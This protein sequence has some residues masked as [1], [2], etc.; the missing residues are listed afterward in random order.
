MAIFKNAE[1]RSQ[2]FTEEEQQQL[3]SVLPGFRGLDERAYKGVDA[4]KNS[5]IFTAVMM[6]SSDVASL[7]LE[8]MK[9]N[10]KD[11]S[12]SFLPLMNIKP[13]QYYTGYQ[14]KFILMANA[15]LNGQSFAEIVR[16]GNDKPIAIYHLPNS[17]VGY[18]QSAAPDFNLVY[19]YTE[20]NGTE[21]KIQAADVIHLKFFSLDG[22]EGKSP[23]ISL[24][25]DLSTQKNSK[26]FLSNFFRNGTQSGGML[27]VKGSKLSKE[28]REKLRQEWQEANSGTDQAHKVL[29]LDETM[30]YEPI[31]IDTEI[32]KLINTSNHSTQQVAKAFGIPRH[33]FGLETMNMS[34]EQMNQDYLINTLSPYLESFVAELNFKL[35]ADVDM[36]AKRYWFNTDNQKIIDAEKKNK[37]IRELRDGGLI[38]TDEG[39]EMIG[40]PP[41]PDGLGSKNLVSLNFTT[42][43]MLEEYQMQKAGTSPA[44]KGGEENG[45]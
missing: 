34:L 14:L 42:L 31:E 7:R 5:D 26:K 35:I 16:D 22:I 25:D 27:T 2:I 18:E 33:K 20:A 8:M 36:G 44:P 32:L 30:G 39:R 37:I 19:K 23:L 41:L 4:I 17:K 1:R 13:N 43:D 45:E 24:E 15:L 28:A 10:I 11:A 21:R 6:I 12:D 9:E 3:I 29:V 40:L 38:S